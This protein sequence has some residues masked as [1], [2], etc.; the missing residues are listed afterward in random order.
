M[1]FVKPFVIA[2]MLTAKPLLVLLIICTMP[3]TVLQF[4]SGSPSPIVLTS[5]LSLGVGGHVAIIS[6]ALIFTGI[7]PPF[8][9][10]HDT[11]DSFHVIPMSGTLG[12]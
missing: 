1:L 11:I 4:V 8:F 12:R 9:S 2:S 6:G 5:F 7:E 10:A 3:F